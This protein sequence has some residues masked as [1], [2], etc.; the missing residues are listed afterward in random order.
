MGCWMPGGRRRPSLSSTAVPLALLPRS[1]IFLY[2]LK[3]LKTDPGSPLILISVVF[4]TLPRE[5]RS[6]RTFR[7]EQV[8]NYSSIFHYKKLLYVESWYPNKRFHP[9]TLE[10]VTFNVSF[11]V[12]QYIIPI[13]RL[14]GGHKEPECTETLPPSVRVYY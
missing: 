13:C 14:V 12:Q 10:D 3:D 6:V 2:F 9:G 11:S 7:P 8:E 1:I 5:V 4:C